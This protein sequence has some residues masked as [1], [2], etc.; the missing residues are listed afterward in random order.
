MLANSVRTAE[1]APGAQGRAATFDAPGERAAPA[2]APSSAAS[3]GYARQWTR[4]WHR[5]TGPA[6]TALAGPIHVSHSA[7]LLVLLLSAGLGGCG[8]RA[9]PESTVEVIDLG[10]LIDAETGDFSVVGAGLRRRGLFESAAEAASTLSAIS[11][12]DVRAQGR[13]LLVG[14][15]QKGGESVGRLVR[16]LRA[17]WANCPS[18]DY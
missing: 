10:D 2:S 1:W 9:N 17:A 14:P 7:L 8:S 3:A 18:R 13:Q 16:L 12:A 15:T 6:G 5:G 4:G 11:G